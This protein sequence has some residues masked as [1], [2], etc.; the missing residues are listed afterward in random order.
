[1]DFIFLLKA[2]VLGIV[3]G[4]TEF[5]P[6]SSTGHLVIFSNLINIYE[7]SSK[8]FVDMFNMVIQLGAILAVVV[9]YRSKIIDTVKNLFPSATT[10]VTK[11]G[12]YFWGM[13]VISSIPAALIGIPFDDFIKE[14][15]FNPV[16]VSCALFLGGIWIIVSESKL[17]GSKTTPLSQITI[18]PK[19]ALTIGIFQV[20]SIIPGVSRSASTI[21][22][23]WTV[24]LSTVSAAEYSFFLAIPIMFGQALLNVLKV[25][26]NLVSGEWAA[27]GVGFVVSFVVALVVIKSFLSFL[28]EK[29]LR[30]FGYYRIIFAFIVLIYS[31]FFPFVEM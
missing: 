29:P 21:I 11:S 2:A 20:L 14:R 6:V 23:G 27:L 12:L 17:R 28:Q 19:Q 26:A 30:F 8:E 18:T 9:L 25:Q 16:T 13:I 1:M 15:F 22:G 10:P 4:L 7:H 31:R 3:E 24:G 5:L